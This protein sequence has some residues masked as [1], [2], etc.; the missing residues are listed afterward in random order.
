MRIK[1]A[2]S[3]VR[4]RTKSRGLPLLV[5]VLIAVLTAAVLFAFVPRSTPEGHPTVPERSE[6]PPVNH[7]TTQVKLQTRL[8]TDDA[9]SS[10]F[11]CTTV[12]V[13]DGDGPIW[14]KEGPR[15]RLAGI[16]ARELNESCRSNQPCPDASGAVAQRALER[17]VHGKTLECQQVG[18]SYNRVVA[19]C[20]LPGGEDV[21]CAMIRSHTALRWEQYDP[22]GQLTAC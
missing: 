14:C 16:A 22:K 15:I 5:F 7:G 12:R 8:Q 2:P 10:R 1:P 20:A 21:S 19:W 4:Q 6:N 13:H 9:G 11:L 3:Y 18:T 17:L